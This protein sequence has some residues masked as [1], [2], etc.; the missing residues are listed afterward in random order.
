MAGRRILAPIVIA[1][2]LFVSGAAFAQQSAPHPVFATSSQCIACHS[3]MQDAYGNDVGIG[4]A[5]RGTMMALSAK[6][7]YWMAGVRR[8]IEERPHL[9]EFIEDKCSVCHMPMARTTA[10]ANGGTGKIFRFT[11][12]TAAPDEARLAN[13]GV[14]CTVCHQIS[15]ENFG[16][17]ESFDGGY[18]INTVAAQDPPIF[19]PF[20]VDAGRHRVMNSASAF[21]P[22]QSAHI[23]QS[24]LCATCH[25]LFTP[26]VDGDGKEIG[27]FAEQAPYLEWRHSGYA[28]TR[29][30]QDCHM[31]TTTAPVSS[32]L[33]EPRE[34][35]SL[36]AFRGGNA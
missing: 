25:T 24:E 36:H 4:H 13:D 29:S 7:P 17:D 32:V 33:G 21:Q 18:I 10:V 8:E 9:Q 28:E 31:P 26:A 2:V 34:G 5:W 3:N 20:D 12:G 23:Q 6:D 22:Q 14:T 30:C 35:M 15:A 1:A 16:E 27:Q 11:E 19:G